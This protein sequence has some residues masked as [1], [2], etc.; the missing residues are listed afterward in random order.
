M[1]K[2]AFRILAYAFCI[3][4]TIFSPPSMLS[5]AT[6][7]FVPLTNSLFYPGSGDGASRYYYGQW[8]L[9]NLMPVTSYNAGLD[10]NVTGAWSNG[11]TGNGVIIGICDGGVDLNNPDLS[12]M[13]V[14]GRPEPKFINE[15]SWDFGKT[16]ARNL[17]D[18]ARGRPHSSKESHGTQVAGC[19]AAAGNS[20]A[21]VGVAPDALIA[22]LRINIGGGLDQN[23]TTIW[24]H[25][26]LFQ[27]QQDAYGNPNP[28]SPVNW[29]NSSWGTNGPPIRVKN[30]SQGIPYGYYLDSG[31]L[32]IQEALSQ[33]ASHGVIPVFSAG[34][35]RPVLYQPPGFGPNGSPNT[36]KDSMKISPCAINVASLG[37]YGKYELYSSYGANVFVTTFGGGISGRQNPN[38]K[39]PAGTNPYACYFIPS[40]DLVGTAGENTNS[41]IREG[42]FRP[43]NSTEQWLLDYYSMGMGTSL[44]A[45]LVSGV[46][47]L[48]V[49]ANPNLNVRLAQHLLA[50]TSRQVDSTDS[51]STGGWLTNAAGYRFN[52]NYGFGLID[53]TAFTLAA[54]NV[55][56]WQKAGSNV[57]T[58]LQVYSGPTNNVSKYFVSPTSRVA[59]VTNPL[60]V[61][62]QNPQPIEYVRV[63]LRIDGLQTDKNA[64]EK[65]IG[66]IQGDFSATLTSPSGTANSLFMD[67]H[68][69]QWRDSRQDAIDWTFLSWAYYGE[70]PNG[71]WTLTVKN[72]STSHTYNHA[73]KLDNVS[74]EFGMGTFNTNSIQPL[75]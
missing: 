17:V 71:T 11:Y 29:S 47:A 26:I 23:T 44:A 59:T 9:K 8:E 66:A 54:A 72:T 53:A 3:G 52:N 45:P 74:L 57:L 21:T 22:S 1:K 61:S 36:E 34:N 15:Y 65:G 67:D 13:D 16:P 40:T 64:Y 42:Y 41:N 30:L 35:G 70:N 69:Y 4:L 62:I 51:S 5:Q 32:L 37:A 19:A 12:Y 60:S 68:G 38:A 63:H 43:T 56:D 14:D 27:G 7:P 28:L 33:S 24:A 50:L 31:S 39:N 2:K 48:G 20:N 46:M 73:V 55:Y 6:Q 10:M 18:P 49:Q 75:P 58:P 25:G